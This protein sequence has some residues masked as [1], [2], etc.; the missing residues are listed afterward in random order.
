[1]DGT[2]ETGVAAC[3]CARLGEGCVAAGG[4]SD[5]RHGLSL[6]PCLWINPV[7]RWTLNDPQ[8]TPHMPTSFGVFWRLPLH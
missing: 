1:V 3:D 2:A 6:W 5:P 8:H 4:L 7:D